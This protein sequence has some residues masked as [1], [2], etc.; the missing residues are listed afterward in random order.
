VV[1]SNGEAWREDGGLVRVPRGLGWQSTGRQCA[2][3]RSL[4]VR[5]Q[6]LL[7]FGEIQ[8]VVVSLAATGKRLGETGK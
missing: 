3:V 7:D 2:V 1:A 5:V 8:V 6:L 4:P